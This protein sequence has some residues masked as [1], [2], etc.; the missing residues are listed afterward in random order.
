MTYSWE[1]SDE[2]FKAAITTMLQE[3]KGNTFET[4]GKVGRISREIQEESGKCSS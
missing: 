2:D 4:N 1:L 3:T